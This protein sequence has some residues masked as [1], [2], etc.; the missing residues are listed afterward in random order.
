MP[1]CGLDEKSLL[2][3]KAGG[4]KLHRINCC[5][6]VV[7]VLLEATAISVSTKK[8]NIDINNLHSFLILAYIAPCRYVTI[9]LKNGASKGYQLKMLIMVLYL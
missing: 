1:S 7:V 9:L 6:L 8:Q 4:G 3:M 5:M 2:M